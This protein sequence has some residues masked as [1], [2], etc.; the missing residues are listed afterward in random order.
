MPAASAKPLYFSTEVPASQTAAECIGVLA[1]HG[2]GETTI[3]WDKETREPDGLRFTIETTWGPQRYALPVKVE[4]TA[5]RLARAHA[6][7]KIKLS[8]TG[9]A[10]ARKVAWRVLK[11][12]LLTQ[13]EFIELGFAELPEIMLPWMETNDGRTVWATVQENQ[14]RAL[15]APRD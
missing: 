10:H 15:E 1:Q 13:V 9:R 3:S 11:A 2:A 14:Q 5:V 4:A 6:E 7:G 8:F 12:W